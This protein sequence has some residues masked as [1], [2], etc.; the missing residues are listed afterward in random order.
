MIA[1][2][3]AA[4]SGALSF[5]RRLARRVTREVEDH[6]YQATAARAPQD[7]AE[8]ERSAVASFCDPRALPM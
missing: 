1:D 5:D 3:L 6:L 7:R 8:A 4:L 2:Y